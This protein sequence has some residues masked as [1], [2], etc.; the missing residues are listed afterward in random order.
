MAA[1][2]DAHPSARPAVVPT[3]ITRP[4]EETQVHFLILHLLP[5]LNDGGKR[6]PDYLFGFFLHFLLAFQAADD[7]LGTGQQVGG[8]GPDFFFDGGAAH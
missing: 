5:A 8:P 6:R 7:C 1:S 4:P 2:V 3:A